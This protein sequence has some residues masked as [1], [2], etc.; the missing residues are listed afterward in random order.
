MSPLRSGYGSSTGL[1]T[2]APNTAATGGG[3]CDHRSRRHVGGNHL[4]DTSAVI[5]IVN[6][7]A[8]E[9]ETNPIGEHRYEV[10]INREVITTFHH[11]RANGLGECL[12]QAAAAVDRKRDLDAFQILEE[13][14]Q[15]HGQDRKVRRSR[16]VA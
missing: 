16:R 15:K 4:A 8:A 9:G 13:F 10:R 12:R 14:Q 2:D 7:G 3:V 1:A 5:A 6:V 11:F